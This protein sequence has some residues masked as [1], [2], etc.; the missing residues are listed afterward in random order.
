ML[1]VAFGESTMSKTQ[2]QLWYNLFKDGREDINNDARPGRPSMSI[3][4]ENLETVK[5][6]ILHNR[7]ITVREVA[8]HVGISFGSCQ[9][10]FTD[11][12]YYIRRETCGSENYSKIAKY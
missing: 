5:K 1:T 7:R 8:G 11:I 4:N 3:T 6:I 9:A 12:I 10:I 2:V